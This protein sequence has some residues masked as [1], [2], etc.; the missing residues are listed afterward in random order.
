[1]ITEKKSRQLNLLRWSTS[2]QKNREPIAHQRFVYILMAITLINAGS[3][4]AQQVQR[5]N[6]ATSG[7]SNSFTLNITQ[8]HGV[9]S[10]ATM[11]PDYMVET[12][13]NLVVGPNSYTRQSA[14]DGTSASLNPGGISGLNSSGV[15]ADTRI[16]YQNGTEY[17][18]IIKPRNAAELLPEQRQ[19]ALS[20]ATGMSS[21]STST[22]L[23]VE[24]TQ[25]SFINSFVDTL[26]R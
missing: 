20:N 19:R 13:A 17:G 6:N 12:K 15:S 9:S 18:V 8:V 11:T 21:G 14:T 2:I 16:D 25:S 22:V 3:V 7:S 26:T 4:D 24:S 23:T 10:S 5:T 1:M